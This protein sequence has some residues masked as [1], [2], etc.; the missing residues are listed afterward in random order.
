MCAAYHWRFAVSDTAAKH[1]LM[2]IEMFPE[3]IIHAKCL[4]G[5][6]D[7]LANRQVT[8]GSFPWCF[9]D[10]ES[11]IGRCVAMVDDDE[12]EE[13]ITRLAQRF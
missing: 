7:L 3:H 1:Q 11:C 2:H 12:Y 6:I 9:V 8:K 4:G 5:D 10:G 13:R